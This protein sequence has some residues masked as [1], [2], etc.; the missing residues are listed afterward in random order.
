MKAV[1]DMSDQ[2]YI[3]HLE[4][5]LSELGDYY[6]CGSCGRL[7]EFSEMHKLCEARLCQNCG[8]GK[9]IFESDLSVTREDVV[10]GR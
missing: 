2:E 8:D 10:N 5:R 9:C 3:L 6:T 1:N 7:Y 4:K